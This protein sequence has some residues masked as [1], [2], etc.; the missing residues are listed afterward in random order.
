MLRGSF[1]VC[2]LCVSLSE[3]LLGVVAPCVVLP[4]ILPYV[5]WVCIFITVYTHL[6]WLQKFGKSARYRD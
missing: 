5:H 2:I 6:F 3:L 4:Y 1:S